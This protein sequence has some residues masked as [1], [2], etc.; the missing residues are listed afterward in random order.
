MGAAG[1]Q[2]VG[3]GSMNSSFSH[4][5]NFTSFT[6]E[7]EDEINEVR[8]ELNFLKKEIHIL[9]L[10]F[11]VGFLYPRYFWMQPKINIYPDFY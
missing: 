6:N 2:M 11:L 10:S 9:N 3:I 5:V 1:H 4:N 7:L 8:K